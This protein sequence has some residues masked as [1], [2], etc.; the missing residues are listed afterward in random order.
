MNPIPIKL[1]A[2]PLRIITVS[3]AL[4]FSLHAGEANRPA[5][6]EAS[7]SPN[8]LFIF[9]DDWGF[10][11]LGCHGNPVVETPHLNML[12]SQGTDFQ[13][14]TVASGVCSPSRTALL[15]GHFPARYRIN[16]HFHHVRHHMANGMP[17]WLSP[18]ASMLPRVLGNH[19][20]TTCHFGKWHLTNIEI[21]DAPKPDLYG[22]QK[23]AVFNGPG[24]QIK[25]EQVFDQAIEVIRNA[26][27]QPFF[28][29]LWI[30]E[31]HTP[32]YPKPELMKH[33]QA[34]GL[35]ERESVYPAVVTNADREI[36]RV[37]KALDEEGLSDNTL[38]IFSSDN[39]PESVLEK[40]GKTI[41]HKQMD[42]GLNTWYSLG[43]SGGL[44]GRKRSLHEGGIRVPLLVRWPKKVAAGKVDKETVITGVDWF[45][46]LCNIAGAPLPQ[47]Y[48]PD[49]EDRSP[50]LLN[51]SSVKNGVS[52]GLQRRKPIFWYWPTGRGGDNWPQ[53][54][55]RDGDWKL[56]KTLDGKRT[57][58]YR[59]PADRA[60]ANNLADQKP[61]L[62]KQLDQQL[63]AWLKQLPEKP[64]PAC[65]SNLRSR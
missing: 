19:G 15:T 8:I 46:T 21:P 40:T 53:A 57:E 50:A 42:P 34:K 24:N 23:H 36:G 13:Q 51:A 47:G 25:P 54:A 5:I 49:G 3:L 20:Y 17:D 10:G 7:S 55:I 32:H 59:I 65:F 18:D 31:T 4:V 14:F 39:G 26:D 16:R 61:E 6:D 11:D 12:A 64:D 58:L 43:S 35:S 44:R 62:A 56:L 41:T 2:Q 60:E 27:N 45:P 48:Q 37:L 9:A 38:V 52:D 63:E 30:H 28:I 1:L 22:Y 29:N 33:Y